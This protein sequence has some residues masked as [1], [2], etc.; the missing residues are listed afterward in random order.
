[1]PRTIAQL[2][3]LVGG[4]VAGDA[5]VVVTG[6]ASIERATAGTIVFADNPR[7]FVQAVASLA[8]AIV[9]PV[10]CVTE[11]KPVIHVANPKLAF[12]RIVAELVPAQT[13][14]R[15]VHATAV[16]D[17]TAVLGVDVSVGAW[18][19]VGSKS[20]IGD[21]TVIGNGCA[22]GADVAFG[23]EC[24]VH[25]NVTIHDRV[26]IGDRAI[27]HSGVV[28]GSDGFGFVFEGGQ[29]HKFPQVG[30]VEIGD[31]VEIGANTTIDRGALDSTVIGN[32]TK[33]DNLVQ[34]GHNVRV[35]RNCVIAAQVGISGSAT[36]GDGVMFGGQVGVGDH[37]RIEDGAV[38]G[39]QSGILNG[40]VIRKGSFVW[41][42]PARPMDQFRRIFAL[43]QNLPALKARVESLERRFT[44]PSDEAYV[45]RSSDPGRPEAGEE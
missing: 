42:T 19:S 33:I 18:S 15:T 20:V 38:L 23:R 17:P 36:I 27:V 10:G 13:L 3:E 12:A 5:D 32:G 24:L 14:I 6:V 21:G 37:A 4:T 8:S 28:I 30:D 40:K 9:A 45:P 1:M 35:G 7:A 25:A 16:V 43:V 39:G 11:E 41:G 34:I 31:D 44:A 22:I 2:A 26:R 29:F